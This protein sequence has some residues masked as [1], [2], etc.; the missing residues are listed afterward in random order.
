[1]VFEVKLVIGTIINIDKDF[2]KDSEKY[3]SK[4][5]DVGLDFVMIDYPTYVENGK[6]AFL[7]DGT[8]LLISFTDKTENLFYFKTEVSGR[9]RDGIPMLKLSYPGDDKVVQ[10]QRREFVRTEVALDV[11]VLKDGKYTKL[12][13]KDISAGGLGL[14]LYN[15]MYTGKDQL[16][17]IIVLPFKNKEIKY[18]RTK[19][20]VIRISE[21]PNKKVASVQF[22]GINL[23]DRQWI[24]RYCFEQELKTRN[25]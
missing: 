14:N 3:K 24:I 4:I 19:A 18:I 20:E 1:M 17:L 7:L 22:I 8:Q 16:S 23:T 9:R 10:I 12:V 13:T 2:S 6:T 21:N 5:I 15:A 11:A 25:G